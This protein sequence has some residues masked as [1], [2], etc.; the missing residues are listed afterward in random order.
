MS[1][2]LCILVR[3]NET[4]FGILTQV[5]FYFHYMTIFFVLRYSIDILYINRKVWVW[6]FWF[7]GS[8]FF[9]TGSNGSKAVPDP[10]KF[11]HAI[12]HDFF[13]EYFLFFFSL[14][15]HT[16]ARRLKVVRNLSL[17]CNIIFDGPQIWNQK[18]S[19]SKNSLYIETI[20]SQWYLW[21]WG[22]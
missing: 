8:Q 1:I 4:F 18:P 12:T 2:R 22:H 5:H 20:L 19:N 16:N 6:S 7:F 13:N 11:S 3:W 21:R 17:P 10:T 14:K 15:L 9:W